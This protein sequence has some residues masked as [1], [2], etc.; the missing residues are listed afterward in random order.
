ML[1][2]HRRPRPHHLINAPSDN[3]SSPTSAFRG[4]T[5][6]FAM[7]AKSSPALQPA[8]DVAHPRLSQ[9]L[10]TMAHRQPQALSRPQKR[11]LAR[12]AAPSTTTAPWPPRHP[13]WTMASRPPRPRTRTTL[14]PPSHEPCPSS[15]SALR[16]RPHTTRSRRRRGRPENPCY[17][18]PPAATTRK[19]P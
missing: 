13:P 3:P 4:L 6:T 14:F 16:S 1:P 15:P 8:I 7:C 2:R 5:R 12:S 19:R 18:A 9:M 10:L 17:G 11:R